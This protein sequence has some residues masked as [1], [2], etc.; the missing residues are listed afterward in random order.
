L[1]IAI[2]VFQ[3]HSNLS[4][5]LD[6]AEGRSVA[7][8]RRPNSARLPVVFPLREKSTAKLGRYHET[9][10]HF[11]SRADFLLFLFDFRCPEIETIAAT[12]YQIPCN[13]SH[14]TLFRL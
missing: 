3:S 5:L 2:L 10:P 14:L 7:R 4:G 9:P 1:L 12:A 13:D 8:A 6:S 11:H